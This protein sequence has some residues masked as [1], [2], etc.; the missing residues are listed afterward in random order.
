MANQGYFTFAAD[1]KV[2]AGETIA[3]LINV[4]L[5]AGARIAFAIDGAGA[6]CT[7]SVPIENTVAGNIST[8]FVDDPGCLKLTNDP[9]KP[10]PKDSHILFPRY[11]AFEKTNPSRFYTSFF[12]SRSEV[13]NG[14]EL[15]MP[16]YLE[17]IGDTVG[18]LTP[19]DL[20]T[21]DPNAVV[22]VELKVNVPLV[23]LNLTTN[24]VPKNAVSFYQK[25]PTSAAL[26]GKIGHIRTVLNS[27]TYTPPVDFYGD[28]TLSMTAQHGPLRASDTTRL[29]IKPNCANE[30]GVAVRFDFGEI[31]PVTN[32]FTVYKY[33]TTISRQ[34]EHFP[35]RS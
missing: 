12:E 3:K 15:S 5:N 19:I 17:L 18:A 10:V 7:A 6:R 27:L 4:P 8:L 25:T 21:L 14:I 31:D 1:C 28:D 16:D 11:V 20:R 2:V 32:T 26:T 34:T 29:E 24:A 9:S 22:A 13:S 30:E 23:Q 33:L 35:Q